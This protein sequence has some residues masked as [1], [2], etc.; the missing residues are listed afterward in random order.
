MSALSAVFRSPTPPSRVVIDAVFPEID[1]GNSASKGTVGEPFEVTAHVFADGHD[2]ITAQLS[3]H[4][5]DDSEWEMV[6]LQ[7]LG[8]DEWS[9][10]FIPK[11]L[12]PHEYTVTA[13]VDHF[14]TWRDDLERRIE[15]GWDVESELREGAAI[16]AE[17][18]ERASGEDRETLLV[19]SRM[20]ADRGLGTATRARAAAREDLATLSEVYRDRTRDAIRLPALP[21]WVDRERA[22]FGAW[23]E[24]FPRSETP[25]P[26]RGATFREAA[27][28]LSGIAAMGFDVLYLPPIH[29]I[30]KTSRKGPDNRESAAPGDPGSPWAIGSLEGGHTAVHPEL[31][32]IEDFDWF[33]AEAAN[34]GLEVALDLA[35]QCSPD[36]PWVTEHPQWFRQR[37]DGTI[38]Y[39][40]N[41]PKRYQDIYPIDF[42]TPDWRALWQALLD[43]VLFWSERGVH[44]FRVDNPH[45]KPFPFW[46]W[47]IAETRKQHPD[48]IFLAEAF[49]RPKRLERLAKLGFTQS[50]TYFTWRNTKPE[51]QE[52]LRELT[53]P[54]TRD[55]L[56][57]NFFPNTPDILHE[58]LQEGGRPAFLVRLALAATMGP[59]Y[60]IYSGFEL[61]EATPA[62]AG[63][64]E[65]LH[66]EKYQVRPRRW[67]DSESIAAQIT[68]MNEV[69]RAYP[70]LQY[71]HALWFLPIQNDQLIA[72][73]KSAP[74][75]TGHV[76]TVVNLDVH[77]TQGGWVG[78]PLDA[79]GLPRN[80]AFRVREL[81]SDEQQTWFGEWNQ[82]R[83]SPD[84]PTQLFAFEGPTEQL[85]AI[86]P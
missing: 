41:P 79:L 57:P 15:A 78:L 8:N 1:G 71:N 74:D 7:P 13:W 54:P 52:Y 72:Y 70:A 84:A 24:M 32:T 51:L 11:Q 66:S 80:A 58:Y 49:T 50:Y 12:G 63:S 40:E 5:T 2:R 22:R 82:V 16:L 67:D 53:T 38:K 86:R 81:L 23:Y 42:D 43:V 55:F 45:T 68:R 28:R 36:H 20:L 37:P 27:V 30:G 60:G 75:G 64:E 44:I 10:R 85:E 25:D 56:R 33:V 59:S 18:A 31:G 35:Y 14:G 69:R 65:Y 73:I 4:Q 39:A 34:H 76:L 21:L 83:L 17:C 46:E 6:P 9:A 19:A 62:A 77:A 47:L 3:W 61:L 48:T 29:P 26:E